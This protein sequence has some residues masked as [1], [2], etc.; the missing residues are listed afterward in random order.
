MIEP[1]SPGDAVTRAPDSGR[2]VEKDQMRI[3]KITSLDKGWRDKD[4]V[5]LHAAFQLLVDFVENEKPD[6]RLDW[7]VSLEFSHAWSEIRSLYKWWT[8]TRPARKDPL[9]DKSLRKPP[10]RWK[11]IQGSECRQ[12]M[13]YDKTKYPEYKKAQATH[14]RLEKKW[15]EEDQR[16]FH[17]LVDIRGFLWT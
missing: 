13:H 2:S 17:R 9:H 8:Q 10:M 12:L 5:M 6:E 1:R 15:E 11:K 14:S 4:Y 7:G 3:L 16:N